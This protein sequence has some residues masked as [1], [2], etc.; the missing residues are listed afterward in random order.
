VIKKNI[1]GLGNT[2]RRCIGLVAIASTPLR[3]I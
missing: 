3:I 1:G 2:R